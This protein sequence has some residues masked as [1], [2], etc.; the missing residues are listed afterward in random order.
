V[1]LVHDRDKRLKLQARLLAALTDGV[2]DDEGVYTVVGLRDPDFSQYPVHGET[3]IRYVR[4]WLKQN[5]F[6]FTGCEDE[7]AA[8]IVDLAQQALG[9]KPVPLDVFQAMQELRDEELQQTLSTK[10]QSERQTTSP[11]PKLRGALDLLAASDDTPEVTVP[12]RPFVAKRTREDAE[13]AQLAMF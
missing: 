4:G 7:T 11:P 3:M 9:L 13:P 10:L 12:K 6:V 8:Q 5:R 1:H 2:Q